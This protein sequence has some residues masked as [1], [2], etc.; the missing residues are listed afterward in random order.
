M[1]GDVMDEVFEPVDRGSLEV[2]RRLEAFA[3]TR[4]EP[5]VAATSRMRAAVMVAAHRQAA[6]LAADAAGT[7]VVVMPAA[8]PAE[9]AAG[10]ARRPSWLDAVPWRRPA[11]AIMAG[12]LTLGVLAGTALAVRPGGPLYAARI[13]T[14]AANLPAADEQ[15]ARAQAEIQRLG[16]RLGEVEAAAAAGDGPALS[17]ALEAYAAIVRE[18]AAGTAGDPAAEQAVQ[19]AIERHM[20]VLTALAAT[21][22]APAQAALQHAIASSTEALDDVD[23]GPGV[24]GTNNGN[25]P[26]TNNGNGPS[27]NGNNGAGPAGG[28]SNTN[29]AAGGGNAGEK[30]DATPVPEP[31]ATPKPPKATPPPHD[32]TPRPTATH[33]PP[34]QQGGDPSDPPAQDQQ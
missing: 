16:A 31:T 1:S 25:G 21:V 12:C 23:G 15:L 29:G 33:E 3:D 4:L 30:P 7:A 5:T 27:E 20:L 18:A 14:E 17:A 10:A 2:I 32:R 8:R 9:T 19:Q 24:P 6:L 28:G 11:A 13:W 34:G 22:P 26:G